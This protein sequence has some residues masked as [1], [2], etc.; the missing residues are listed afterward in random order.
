MWLENSVD[1]TGRPPRVIR[2]RHRR[3]AEDVQIRDDP[4]TGQSITQPSESVLNRSPIE[5]WVSVAHATPSS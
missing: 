5:E 1:V 2:Q 4:T 3:T